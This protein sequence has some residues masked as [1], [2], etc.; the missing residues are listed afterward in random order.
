MRI[1]R[2]E[3]GPNLF[4]AGEVR[5]LID[6]AGPS[7]RAMILLGINCGFGNA[8]C[9]TMPLSAVDLEGAVIDFARPRTD[10]ARRCPLW[11]GTV[12]ANLEVVD[13]RPIPKNK[14]NADLVFLTLHRGSWLKEEYT[15]PMVLETRKLWKRLGING[16][17]RLGFYTLR[18]TF[19]TVADESRDQIAVDHIMGHVDESMAGHY[20][21]RISDERLRAVAEHV[22][23]WLCPSAVSIKTVEQPHRERRVRST[24]RRPG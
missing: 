21:E 19:R 2:A 9:G 1:H 18:H 3:R 23:R 17:N 16:R 6:A 8:D 22:R 12:A 7:M 14:E 10:I 15:S 5:R 20:R 24:R 13:R 4:T 11:A